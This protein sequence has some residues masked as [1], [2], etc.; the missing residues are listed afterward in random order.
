[1]LKFIVDYLVKHEKQL[2][3]YFSSHS[4]GVIPFIVTIVLGLIIALAM[5]SLVAWILLRVNRGIFRKIEERYG[6]R[7][8][9][10][11]AEKA[12]KVAIIVIFVIIP[13]AG[14][15]ILRSILGSAAVVTAVLGL[16]A[17]DTIK[18]ILSGFLISLYRPFDIGDRIEL[19]NGTTGIVETMTMRNVV[20]VLIDTVRLIIPNSRINTQAIK[21]LSYGYVI[22]SVEFSFQIHYDSDI[23]LAKQTILDA[24]KDSEYSV[25]G[26]K[27][28]TGEMGY[29]PVYF[30]S[31]GESAFVMKTTVYFEQNT[32]SEVVKDDINVRVVEALGKAGIKVPYPYTSVILE[33]AS[34]ERN[35]QSH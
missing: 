31:I 21:N 26:K 9:L 34:H 33:E 30:I 18:D 23:A 14:D 28:K 7:L 35:K 32:P 2:A 8:H 16:A 20:L 12:I 25:P 19:E 29:A 11:F 13:L 24:V 4:E 1:M 10:R 3:S 17:Q 22:K 5:Y 27:S 15:E 6:K